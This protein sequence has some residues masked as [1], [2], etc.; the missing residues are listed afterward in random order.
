MKKENEINT[1]CLKCRYNCKQTAASRIIVCPMYQESEN[2]FK[3]VL[4]SES[5]KGRT[6]CQ[7][8]EKTPHGLPMKGIQYKMEHRR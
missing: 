1:L 2:E 7:R 5:P 6:M 4:K 3:D 8:E